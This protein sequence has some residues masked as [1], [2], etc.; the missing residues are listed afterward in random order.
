M[1]LAY[2]AV[3]M[4][5]IVGKLRD[6]EVACSASYHQGS[7]FES[8]VWRAVSSHSYNHPQEI[9]LAQF[10]LDEHKGDLNPLSFISLLSIKRL[11]VCVLLFCIE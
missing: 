1:I 8:S 2:F 4:F 11:S 7:N 5:N 3:K 9:L 10:S 6:R